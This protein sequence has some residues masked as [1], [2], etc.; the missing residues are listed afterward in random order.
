MQQVAHVEGR[1]YTTTCPYP[2]GTLRL[3]RR[4]FPSRSAFVS[5][6][7]RFGRCMAWISTV[8]VVHTRSG[9]E[10]SRR[11]NRNLAS[12]GKINIGTYFVPSSRSRR[13]LLKLRC[14]DAQHAIGL[15]YVALSNATR[16]A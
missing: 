12:Q 11:G 6:W 15:P 10:Y 4:S 14:G 8:F 2:I 5:C 9:Y 7:D 16:E 3:S 13:L 1:E